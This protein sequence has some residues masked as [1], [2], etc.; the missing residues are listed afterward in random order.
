MTI[1]AIL[2]TDVCRKYV[3]RHVHI[4]APLVIKLRNIQVLKRTDGRREFF[5]IRKGWFNYKYLAHNGYWAR[6]QYP[7]SCIDSVGD[8]WDTHVLKTPTTKADEQVQRI[9]IERVE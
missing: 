5:Y 6:H 9:Y 3:K 1:N 2:N 4:F 7:F 8:A